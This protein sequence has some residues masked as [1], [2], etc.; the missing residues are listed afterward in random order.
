MLS[1]FLPSLHI[2]LDLFFSDS[3]HGLLCKG[4]RPYGG[5]NLHDLSQHGN[6]ELITITIKG[7]PSNAK[8]EGTGGL[9]SQREANLYVH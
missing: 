4:E 2:A 7:K 6:S 1:D 3:N 9:P 5:R 8:I